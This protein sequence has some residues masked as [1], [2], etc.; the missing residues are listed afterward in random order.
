[1]ASLIRDDMRA[2]L[3]QP[4]DRATSYPIAASDIRRWAIA[5]YYPKEPPRRFID[6]GYAATTP[7]G[8]LVA[9]DEFNPFAWGAQETN[10]RNAPDDIHVDPAIIAT[11][12][13]E[14]LLGI[15][16]PDLRRVLNGGLDVSHTGV[17][18]RAGDV[19]TSTAAIVDY[20]ESEGRLGQM[21]F[22]TT[23]SRWTNQDDELV[24]TQRLTLIRY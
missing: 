5:V 4:F 16:P 22:T 9:P 8:G 14:H 17:P 19:I 15:A 11:G 24:K 21:L 23:E 3:G 2:I 10:R 7:A 13:S 18:M 20:R 12:A 6:E 1:M